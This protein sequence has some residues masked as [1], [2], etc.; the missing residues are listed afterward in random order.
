MKSTTIV[1]ALAAAAFVAG[2]LVSCSPVSEQPSG[3]YPG[4]VPPVTPTGSYISGTK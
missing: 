1:V 4:S 2:V 3:V